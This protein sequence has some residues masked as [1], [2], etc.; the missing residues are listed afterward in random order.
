LNATTCNN[1]THDNSAQRF[2][3]R[4]CGLERFHTGG[5]RKPHQRFCIVTLL[6][7]KPDSIFLENA[8]AVVA[9]G[10]G[11]RAG[12]MVGGFSGRAG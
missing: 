5:N 10:L 7:G 8:P 4:L 2:D 12:R 9:G 3:V 6:D 11:L 1:A